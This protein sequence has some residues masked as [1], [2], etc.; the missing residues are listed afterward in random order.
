MPMIERFN[1]VKNPSLYTLTAEL[2]DAIAD[3]WIGQLPRSKER[4]LIKALVD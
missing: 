4:G 1:P 2:Q 3:Y